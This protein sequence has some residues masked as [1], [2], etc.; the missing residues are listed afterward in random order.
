MDHV[1]FWMN[2]ILIK[3]LVQLIIN[4][5]YAFNNQSRIALWNLARLAETFLHLI[6]KNEEDSNKKN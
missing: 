6:D 5:R 4:G 2:I 1:H 3:F